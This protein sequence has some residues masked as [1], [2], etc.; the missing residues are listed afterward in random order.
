M[1]TGRTHRTLR[2][3]SAGT[4]GWANNATQ[5]SV[6]LR[7]RITGYALR[8][9][10]TGTAG[11]TG[12]T[13]QRRA[14]GARASGYALHAGGTGG[15]R[16]T[17]RTCQAGT[18]STGFS[19]RALRAG[20]TGSPRFTCRTHH[21][22]AASTCR[23][24]WTL[25]TG[26]AG[27]TVRACRTGHRGADSARR[28]G[29]A[30]HANRTGRTVRSARADQAGRRG[31]ASRHGERRNDGKQQRPF[32][33]LLQQHRMSHGVPLV[34]SNAHWSGLFA[35]KSRVRGTI[36]I[37]NIRRVPR[38]NR[39][40]TLIARFFPRARLAIAPDSAVRARVVKRRD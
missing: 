14:L 10:N 21:R 39:T 36:L 1:C 34:V 7:S 5:F 16:Y 19:D 29:R 15:S 28:S 32:H 40:P 25:N 11:W 27:R 31:T 6:T 20:R 4:T 38:S 35:S 18:L 37:D 3:G 13:D 24:D 9:C 26:R 12:R 2:A 30:L 8:A 22:Y 33:R 17:G 23:T